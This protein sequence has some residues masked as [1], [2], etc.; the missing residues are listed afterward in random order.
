VT[1]RPTSRRP[2]SQVG[3]VQILEVA[4]RCSEIIRYRGEVGGA[5]PGTSRA[6]SAQLPTIDATQP[7]SKS[8]LPAGK[9]AGV[10]LRRFESCTCHPAKK[11]SDQRKRRSVAAFP[12]TAWG[13]ATPAVS[14]VRSSERHRPLTCANACQRFRR[15]LCARK[16]GPRI[17]SRTTNR[18]SDQRRRWGRGYAI[19]A[20]FGTAT[21]RSRGCLTCMQS[22]WMHGPTA[23]SLQAAGPSVEGPGGATALAGSIAVLVRRTSRHAAPLVQLKPVTRSAVLVPNGAI[24]LQPMVGIA[25]LD[26]SG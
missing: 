16:S 2:S 3:R 26:P 22:P 14:A 20:D 15:A 21:P 7:I 6:T 23:N 9:S 19:A 25:W 4:S 8:D 13:Y 10:H 12:D 1:A 17:D 24:A 18:W 11:A 5:I